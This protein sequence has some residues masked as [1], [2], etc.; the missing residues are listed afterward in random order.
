[1]N[2]NLKS[3]MS[4]SLVSLYLFF[5]L[6]LYLPPHANAKLEA[7]TLFARAGNGDYYTLY[8]EGI[9]KEEAFIGGFKS[10][11]LDPQEE[12]IYF[13]D[14]TLKVIGRI[15][16]QDG[17]VYKVI[18]KPKGPT[19]LDY[20]LPIKFND[21]TLSKLVDF[22]FDK[23]GNIFIL[24]NTTL[25]D[26]NNNPSNGDPRI[27]K[28]SLKDETL[29][30]VLKID[31]QYKAAFT[32]QNSYDLTFLFNG[33]TTDH[34]GTIF[35]YGKCT[36]KLGSG[37]TIL[38][39]NP[40]IYTTELYAL[41]AAISIPNTSPKIIL[42][43]NNSNYFSLKGITF[44]HNNIC[45]LSTNDYVNSSWRVDTTKIISNTNPTDDTFIQEMF[46]GDG[47]GSPSDIG[48]GGYAAGAY[49]SLAGSKCLCEDKSG[50]V[51]IADSGTNRIRKIL[52]DSGLI[53]TVVGGGT[54]LV[55]FGQSKSPRSI[56][57]QSPNS[58]LVD[59][60]DNLYIVENNRILLANNLITHADKPIQT[61]KVANLAITKIAGN[62]IKNPKGD[63]T[64]PDLTLDY[65]YSGDQTIE[66]KGENIPDGT[67]IK[68]LTTN[69][70]GTIPQNPPSG[71]LTSGLTT[72]PIKVEAGL[73]KV[74]KAETD[75]FIPAPGVYLPGTEPKTEDSQLP[76]DPQ[77][78]TSKR[79]AVNLI[80]K[81][82]KGNTTG[83][84]IPLSGRFN[85]THAIGW[86]NYNDKIKPNTALDPD[87]IGF[88]ASLIDFGNSPETVF[89]ENDVE[90]RA[91]W[92]KK[93]TFSIW[94][95]SDSTNINV[96][97]AIGPSGSN[98][99]Q[100]VAY[101]QL[102]NA[103]L[104]T[105]TTVTVTPTWQKFLITS[106]DNLNNFG[107]TLF[108]GGLN[109]TTNQKIYAWGARLEQA[110][111]KFVTKFFLYFFA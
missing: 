37:Q 66:V 33:I 19:T 25:Y 6:G 30:E 12:N 72:I 78:A 102:G 61:V 7:I 65:T 40:T 69:P 70:D 54:E 85:F 49:A 45:Y 56:L 8:P 73:T 60:L 75:P 14:P 104:L 31:D 29:K 2:L 88:D 107:K 100:Y 13:F 77:I 24:L 35:L 62:E 87:N 50:N 16:L 27:L 103:P 81:D 83:N 3:K 68:L 76:L 44:D 38:K 90:V 34:D 89:L 106:N 23:Y 55:S 59:K 58:L 79:D 1:M 63:I 32:Y 21:A 95:R 86:R 48:D 51:Y 43:P 71:K 52:K 98:Y 67:N 20:S 36:S 47:T 92:T 9:K 17:K 97:I 11:Q 26:G 96:P 42:N 91:P 4:V 22:T 84:L 74:I 105:Y 82:A 99:Q 109:Q 110:Q 5:S 15:N 93:V 46:I 41:P 57:L 64:L 108:I 53:T 101:N 111:W 39:F 28:A 94:M 80:I 18:G 10:A